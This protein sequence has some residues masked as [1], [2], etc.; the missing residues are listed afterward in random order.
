M[1]STRLKRNRARFL[2]AAVF[3]LLFLMRVKSFSGCPYS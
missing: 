1:P 2:P 3:R